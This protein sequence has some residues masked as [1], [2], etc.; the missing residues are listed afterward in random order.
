MRQWP[1][2]SS[3]LSRPLDGESAGAPRPIVVSMRRPLDPV[4]LAT[5]VVIG[6]T[7]GGACTP[8]VS[9]QT[10]AD[11]P[12]STRCAV[13]ELG[14][15]RMCVVLL[16]DEDR[17]AIGER[18]DLVRG[19]FDADD[20]DA[21]PIVD[22]PSEGEGEGE[23]DAVDPDTGTFI[24]G[25]RHRRT[26]TIRGEYV[27]GYLIGFPALIVIEDP[28]LADVSNGGYV[29]HADGADLSFRSVDGTDTLDHDLQKYVRETGRVVAWVRLPE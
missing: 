20:G 19:D 17:G 25:F 9:C 12:S 22:D 1:P 29:M 4:Q 15:A 7:L 28:A 18:Q 27:H 16:S 3:S 23:A 14:H 26:I 13:Q 10:D 24:D 6:A 11:C 5:V 21:D 2:T 8:A